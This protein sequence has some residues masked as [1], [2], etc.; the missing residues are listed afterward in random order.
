[1]KWC[2]GCEFFIHSIKWE[3]IFFEFD[4]E[5]KISAPAE[6]A[7]MRVNKKTKKPTEGEEICPRLIPLK[8][9]SVKEG[10]YHFSLN[11]CCVKDRSFLENGQWRIC[12]VCEDN[13]YPVNVDY[14]LAYKSDELSRVF[15]YGKNKYAYNVTFSVN[16]T[17][18]QNIELIINSYFL[19]V[20]NTWKKRRYVE[21]AFTLKG[22]F[23]RMYKVLVIWLIRA[24]Y[25][26]FSRITP[27]KGN[28]ILFMTE[29]KDY[30]TGNLRFIYNRIY[31]R[32]LK[33]RFKI[34]CSCRKAVM[35][36][37]SVKSWV[38]AVYY[39]AL[40]DFIFIDDYAPVF[41]L[42]RLNSKT[43]LIQVWH[44]GEGFKSVGYSRFGKK[45]SPFPMESCH[46]AYTY[47][48]TGSKRLQK[49]YEEV[50]GIER[51]AIL[52]YGMARLDG[53]LNP[54]KIDSFKKN[55][56]TEYPHLKDKKI[57]LFAPTFRGAG[58]KQA[59]YDYTK[60]DF[61]RLYDWCNEEYAVLFKMHPFINNTP[62]IPENLQDRLFDFSAYKDINE[63][64]YVTDILVTDYSS[65]YYEFALME[66]PIIFY[67]YDREFY[68]LARGVHRS[69][70]E[71]AP[72]KVCDTFEELMS[73]LEKGDFEFSKTK[74]FIKENFSD[75]DGQATDRVIDNILL[76]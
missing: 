19:K 59:H 23:K 18:E 51:A 30:L 26:V 10:K 31:E 70:K 20:N 50:F 66:K 49:V 62:E 71:S 39:A 63:L 1:M 60:V 53:F 11:I 25:F 54:E 65:N 34:K 8:P 29:T 41:G 9:E 13:I 42:F 17:A 48:L 52:P 45:D 40:S 64:Y 74:E 67:T 22:K 2:T 21:E 37:M 15:K 73:A 75:Y 36:N 7:L 27:K 14:A 69:V 28:R 57:L 55:F 12:A 6:F 72:G 56:Y 32:G 76:Q 24:F 61:Q 58:Q 33:N 43:K 44:A 5:A 38:K 3:R 68:E 46:K 4:I 16:E 47:A 35:T